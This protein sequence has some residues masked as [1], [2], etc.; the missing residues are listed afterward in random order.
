MTAFRILISSQPGIVGICASTWSRSASDLS[1][2]SDSG[3]DDM[4]LHK[5]CWRFHPAG[6]RCPQ[7]F[8]KLW[9]VRKVGKLFSDQWQE[10]VCFEALYVA[11]KLALMQQG[12]MLTKSDFLSLHGWPMMTAPGAVKLMAQGLPII[13]FQIMVGNQ[14]PRRN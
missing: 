10:A 4:Q 7:P 8:E 14:N 13:G 3:G 9:E 5:E 1:S 11:L 2:A 12:V 6:A